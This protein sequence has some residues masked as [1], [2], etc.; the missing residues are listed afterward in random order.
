MDDLSS[1]G[2]GTALQFT[3]EGKKVARRGW[4]GKD[5]WIAYSPGHLGLPYTAFWSSAARDYVERQLGAQLQVMPCW[6]LK[7]VDNTIVMGWN[8]SQAD[9]DAEDWYLVS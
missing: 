6:L 2:I 1:F 7:T 9:L 5:M 8:P 4:N 3:K